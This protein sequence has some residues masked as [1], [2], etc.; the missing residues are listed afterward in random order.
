[1]SQSNRRHQVG[2]S[3][4]FLRTWLQCF[5]PTR[6]FGTPLQCDR[7]SQS[8]SSRYTDA[9]GRAHEVWFENAESTTSKLE[10]AKATGIRGVYLWMIGGE[11]DRTWS[12]L[13][14]IL[15]VEATPTLSTDRPR[16]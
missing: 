9:Q 14:R 15:P 16:R 2:C 13:H 5:G 11:D 4:T 3:T 8:P 1:M 6:A 7:L 12:Q 10:A